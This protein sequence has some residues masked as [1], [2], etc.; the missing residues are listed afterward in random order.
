[1]L[2]PAHPVLQAREG[3]VNGRLGAR[4]MRGHLARQAGRR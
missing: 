1:L 3:C 4:L 2:L